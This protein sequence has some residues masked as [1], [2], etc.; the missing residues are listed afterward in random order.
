MPMSTS[1]PAERQIRDFPVGGFTGC[2][3]RRATRSLRDSPYYRRSG[4]Y[5]YPGVP[6]VHGD[7][8]AFLAPRFERGVLLSSGGHVFRPLYA[9]NFDGVYRSDLCRGDYLSARFDWLGLC[10]G[11]GGDVVAAA[12]QDFLPLHGPDILL[13]GSVNPSFERVDAGYLF[14]GGRFG[15]GGGCGRFHGLPERSRDWDGEKSVRRRFWSPRY[16]YDAWVSDRAMRFL[17][18]FTGALV[19]LFLRG[20]GGIRAGVP[21]DVCTSVSCYLSALAP[22]ARLVGYSW[23][24]GFCDSCRSF[25][26]STG[27]SP[28]DMDGY[29][30]DG[31]DLP[32]RCV[33][34][35]GGHGSDLALGQFLLSIPVE[36]YA[37]GGRWLRVVGVPCSDRSRVVRDALVRS[38][39]G[40]SVSSALDILLCRIVDGVCEAFG[41]DD[42]LRALRRERLGLLFRS[43]A[44][45]AATI[46]GDLL[47]ALPGDV[48]P[49]VSLPDGVREALGAAPSRPVSDPS[50]FYVTGGRKPISCPV[51]TDPGVMAV[52][53]L[54]LGAFR[55]TR[56]VPQQ[57]TLDGVDIDPVG[58]ANSHHSI[59][60]MQTTPFMPDGVPASALFLGAMSDFVHDAYSCY[61]PMPDDVL[62]IQALSEMDI[63]RRLA[64][65]P[66]T[67]LQHVLWGGGSGAVRAWLGLPWDQ[68]HAVFSV[69]GL[70]S[71]RMA[72]HMSDPF[73][74][75]IA[76]EAGGDDCLFDGLA[77]PL[78]SWAML[79][80]AGRASY[81]LRAAGFVHMGYYVS[82][83][84]SSGMK[85]ARGAT[86][87][88]LG[89][90]LPDNLL[91]PMAD[92]VFDGVKRVGSHASHRAKV[93]HVGE[94]LALG[95]E[96][97]F[98]DGSA[99]RVRY[100]MPA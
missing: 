53:V 69:D 20:S 2:S 29:R 13:G 92:A 75:Q 82:G 34:G 30:F 11:V 47:S 26:L 83:G 87:Y 63:V 6:A 78:R 10:L 55:G 3:L 23:D 66:G 15:S 91:S 96:K 4:C 89:R 35:P 37:I 79:P 46:A 7:I 1:K 31:V 72:M 74:Y 57:T 43:L 93:A 51:L 84:K 77:G 98:Q 48:L 25:Y 36:D 8:D 94:L 86:R 12:V 52:D 64:V 61:S 81:L 71:R 17:L 95:M 19:R 28:F 97:G 42:S 85:M 65:C 32:V 99:Y 76:R 59:R 58:V 21:G 41:C 5:S 88:G 39:R 24:V 49:F 9:Q 54:A 100:G 90:R 60:V 16:P 22:Y 38:D 40:L 33:R 45:Q 50:P 68:S 62:P 18:S 14:L 70:A 27:L 80:L 44:A 73:A 56:G 67:V